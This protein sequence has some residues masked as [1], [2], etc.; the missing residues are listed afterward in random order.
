MY[1][2]YFSWITFLIVYLTVTGHVAMYRSLNSRLQNNGGH[3]ADCVSVLIDGVL[4]FFSVYFVKIPG[5][6]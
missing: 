4:L 1:V 2:L 5:E 3:Y 6:S